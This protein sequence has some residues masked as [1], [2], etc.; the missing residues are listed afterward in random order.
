M[1]PLPTG[2][3]IIES[4]FVTVL[5][6][7]VVKRTWRERLLSRPWRPWQATKEIGVRVPDPQLYFVGSVIVGHPATVQ[8][9]I[10]GIRLGRGDF[11]GDRQ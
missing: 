2:R 1:I 9:A 8:A 10:D 4:P 5:E 6:T 11:D 7:R 3:P